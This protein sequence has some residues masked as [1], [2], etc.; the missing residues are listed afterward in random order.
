LR[1]TVGGRGPAAVPPAAL[2]GTQKWLEAPT[3]AESFDALYCM[4]L[5]EGNGFSVAPWSPSGPPV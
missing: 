1:A 3:L 4:D 5:I 2:F